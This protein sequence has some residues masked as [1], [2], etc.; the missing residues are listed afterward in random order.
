MISGNYYI[1]GGVGFAK[2]ELNAFDAALLESKVGNYNLVRI[3]S[4]LP[5][6]SIKKEDVS[7]PQGSFLHTAYSTISYGKEGQIIASGVGVAIPK[8]RSLPG[9]IM[10]YSTLHNRQVVKTKLQEMLKFAMDIRGITDYFTDFFIIDTTSKKDFTCS[11][12][13]VAIW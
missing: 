9:V 2:N 4:I 11:F 13:C 7:L 8:N 5:P 3:S 6:N 10:E 12:A 1:G